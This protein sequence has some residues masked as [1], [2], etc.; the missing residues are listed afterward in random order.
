MLTNS[1][2]TNDSIRP[3]HRLC[4]EHIDRSIRLD[5]ALLRSLEQDPLLEKRLRRLRMV[6]GVGAITALTWA[7]EIGHTS[8]CRSIKQAI[9]YC[10]LCARRD[11]TSRIARSRERARDISVFP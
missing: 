11:L 3:L 7:L 1:D 5:A 6:P 10:G 2:E 4:R 9:S 8:R